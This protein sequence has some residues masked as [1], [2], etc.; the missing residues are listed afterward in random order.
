MEMADNIA[1]EHEVIQQV[2]TVS[3]K[4]EAV[5]ETEQFDPD[6][7]MKKFDSVEKSVMDMSAVVSKLDKQPHDQARVE[8]LIHC[9]KQQ[10]KHNTE[11]Y[12]L[13]VEMNNCFGR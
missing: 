10:Q 8:V 7:Y 9:L 1:D 6:E 3:T 5:E 11:L 13:L 12:N 4:T 2:E